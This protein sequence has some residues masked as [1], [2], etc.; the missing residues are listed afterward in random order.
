MQVS[1]VTV[2]ESHIGTRKCV[3]ANRGNNLRNYESFLRENSGNFIKT[4][5]GI[6]S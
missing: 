2:T 1:L 5:L 6:C 3:P 4:T